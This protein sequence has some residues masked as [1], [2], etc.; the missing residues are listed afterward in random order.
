MGSGTSGASGIDGALVF[1]V[2]T[3]P[4]R[5]LGGHL[6][7]LPRRA[8]IR[9]YGSLSLCFGSALVQRRYRR[10]KASLERIFGAL[11]IVFG[12]KLVWNGVRT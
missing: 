4:C 8:G 2:S 1:S 11:L 6:P 5:I 3:V 12:V 10:V 9:W 7:S